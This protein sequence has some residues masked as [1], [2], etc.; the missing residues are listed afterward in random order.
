MLWRLPLTLYFT[1]SMYSI[2]LKVN[3]ADSQLVGSSR[4]AGDRVSNLPVTSQPTLPPEP[5][6]V[7]SPAFWKSLSPVPPIY[8]KGPA[9]LS[10]LPQGSIQPTTLTHDL[11][12]KDPLLGYSL[13]G[14]K[15]VPKQHALKSLHSV[16]WR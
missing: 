11:I 8:S 14:D 7:L 3:A 1:F 13:K 4:G 12:F 6:S 2:E 16:L 10:A 15:L 9:L 5:Q